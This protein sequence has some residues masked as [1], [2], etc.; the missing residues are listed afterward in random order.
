MSTSLD[1]TTAVVTGASRGFGRA[2]AAT[3]ISSGATVVGLARG[4]EQ[5]LATATE[6][7]AA[8]IPVIGDATDPGVATRVLDRYRPQTLILNAGAI[9]T[10][11]PLQHQTWETFSENWQIDVRQAF[12]WVREVLLTPLDPGSTVIAFSSGAAVNGS[13]LS[14]G[15]AGAKSTV[16]FITT[17]AAEEARLATTD[18]RFISVLPKLTPTTE[19][20]EIAV[21]AYAHRDGQDF[22]S[23]LARLGPATEPSSVAHQVHRLVTDD[24]LVSGSY[25]L[26]PQGEPR[27]LG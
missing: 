24:S 18:V 17:Y 26:P 4:R 25:L 27:L 10:C 5:L 23:Y 19:L 16:R 7:G 2:I 6:L 8:F 13:P 21:A 20:G 14:G 3:L 1:G 12:V 15:Y 22:D 9:P 11:R